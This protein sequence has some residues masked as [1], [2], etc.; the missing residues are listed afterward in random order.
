MTPLQKQKTKQ[1]NALRNS[2]KI[3]E[4]YSKCGLVL[5]PR[6]SELL[7]RLISKHNKIGVIDLAILHI[8]LQYETLI[9]NNKT[10]IYPRRAR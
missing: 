7:G 9:C 6:A 5:K 1:T 8:L 3:Y 10:L 4:Y 2:Q